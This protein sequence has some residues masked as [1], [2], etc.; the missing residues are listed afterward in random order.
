MDY[1]C[2]NYLYEIFNHLQCS[3]CEKWGGSSHHSRP[4]SDSPELYGVNIMP[5]HTTSDSLGGRHT[6][7]YL[8]THTHTQQLYGQ[9]N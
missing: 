3:V 5:H 8:Q 7:T 4:A 1:N 9:K 6:Q 2:L